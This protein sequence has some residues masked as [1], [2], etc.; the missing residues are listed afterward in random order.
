MRS[1]EIVRAFWIREF[2]D[3]VNDLHL[4]AIETFQ[5]ATPAKS[6]YSPGPKCMSNLL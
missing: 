5:N 6:I 2:L 3:K 4:D 1:T